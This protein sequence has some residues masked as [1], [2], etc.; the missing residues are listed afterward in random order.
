MSEEIGE[1]TV[2]EEKKGGLEEFTVQQCVVFKYVC[3]RVF[4]A[5]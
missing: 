3:S 5:P 1:R 2:K 4:T